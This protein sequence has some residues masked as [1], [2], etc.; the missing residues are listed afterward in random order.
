MQLYKIHISLF[1]L[2]SVK[3]KYPAIEPVN[4]LYLL[5]KS[6]LQVMSAFA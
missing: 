4:D 3:Q 5:N 6:I 1:R 2:I